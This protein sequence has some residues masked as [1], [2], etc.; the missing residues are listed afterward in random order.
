[1][2][3][4]QNNSDFKSSGNLIRTDKDFSVKEIFTVSNNEIKLGNGQKF[5]RL[6][7]RGANYTL[8]TSDYLIGVTAL[9]V[10]TALGLPD[11]TRVG[12]GKTYIIK[13]EVGGAGSTT[14]TINSDGERNIDGS[15]S[16]TLT[17][18]YQSKTFYSDGS[19]WFTI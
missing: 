6:G 12:V 3:P 17:T 1:M 15:V 8:N 7:V 11:P 9:A 18:N 2:P 5:K 14:I 16:T 10:T 19:N 4:Q 13:D